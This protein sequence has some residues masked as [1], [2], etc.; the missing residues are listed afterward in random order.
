MN[1][2]KFIPDD[3]QVDAMNVSMFLCKK[4]IAT[5]SVVEA[6]YLWEIFSGSQCA[7]WLI[8]CDKTLEDFEYFM[9]ERIND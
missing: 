3:R 8:V 7:S 5:V 4:D 6:Y 9:K 2:L 1:L